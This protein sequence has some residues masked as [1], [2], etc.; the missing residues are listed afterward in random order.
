MTVKLSH[1]R[2]KAIGLFSFN[3]NTLVN[4]SQSSGVI[5]KITE[6]AVQDSAD[7]AIKNFPEALIFDKRE[8]SDTYFL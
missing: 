5:N 1:L 4:S 8:K 2:T 7:Y 3:K 6:M